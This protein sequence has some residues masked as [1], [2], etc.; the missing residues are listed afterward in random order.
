MSKGWTKFPNYLIDGLA[1]LK[2]GELKVL[3]WLLRSSYH[4]RSYLSQAKIAEK[5][6]KDRRSVS[7]AISSLKEKGI[8]Q[9]YRYKGKNS[10]YL[11]RMEPCAEGGGKEEMGN[12]FPQGRERLGFASCPKCSFSAPISNFTYL[13]HSKDGTKEFLSCPSCQTRF[14]ILTGRQG[15][16]EK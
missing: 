4:N 3:L 16:E 5:I 14:W 11:V 15:L 7:R 13:A 8:V 6:R 9:A 12:R 2:A 10:F 1:A